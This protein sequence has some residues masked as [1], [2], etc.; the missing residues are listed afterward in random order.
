MRTLASA[1]TLL[2]S[3]TLVAC[4]GGGDDPDAPGGG[5]DSPA[6]IDAPR[7][8]AYAG[9]D[10]PP[11]AFT[12]NGQ[13]IPTTAPATVDI[14]G[15]TVEISLNG[16]TPVA[17]TRVDLFVQG[18]T[19]PVATAMSS[20]AM[21]TFMFANQA[22]GGVPVDGY[23]KATFPPD[24]AQARKNVFVYPPTPIYADVMNALVTSVKQ[25][26]IDFINLV[27]DPDQADTNG[28]VGI[29]VTDCLG[30]PLAGA[31]VSTT[32]PGTDILYRDAAGNPDPSA[33]VTGPDGIGIVFNVPTGAVTVDATYM[34]YDMRQHGI[35][36]RALGAPA[37][38]LT[39]TIVAP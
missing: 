20:G 14:A 5:I 18:M 8:D 29:L 22:T 9:P 3:L 37:N 6:T 35:T 23:L 17:N 7:A 1:A 25:Q 12:C 36:V 28:A 15:R 26:T 24:G 13:Q 4:G 39:T 16:M 19:T 10:A 30:N 2:A 32:P 11:G 31:A 34:S 27:I 33:T 38:A 21:A